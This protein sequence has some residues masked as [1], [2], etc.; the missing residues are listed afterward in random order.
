MVKQNEVYKETARDLSEKLQL[1]ENTD[2]KKDAMIKS[3]GNYR[4]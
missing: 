4:D 1:I 3:I 2:N